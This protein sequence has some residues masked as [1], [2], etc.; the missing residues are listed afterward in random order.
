LY[1]HRAYTD[2]QYLSVDGIILVGGTYKGSEFEIDY[3]DTRVV[4]F[5]K[6]VIQHHIKTVRADGLEVFNTQ[7]R[8]LTDEEIEDAIAKHNSICQEA[9][10]WQDERDSRSEQLEILTHRQSLSIGIDQ[11]IP[12][13]KRWAYLREKGCP[14]PMWDTRKR[15]GGRDRLQEFIFRNASR[16]A[17]ELQNELPITLPPSG[18]ITDA[19]WRRILSWIEESLNR[20]TQ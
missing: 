16:I 12:H 9:S 5:G 19:R 4:K 3:V 6:V 8:S 20:S 18:I 11:T 14:L 7:V 10:A 17:H 15:P 13:E 1:I 2:S